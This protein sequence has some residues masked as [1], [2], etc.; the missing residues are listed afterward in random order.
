M[1]GL[2]EELHLALETNIDLE[3][4]AKKLSDPS[5]RPLLEISVEN[6]CDWP[7]NSIAGRTNPTFI[8]GSKGITEA[9]MLPSSHFPHPSSFHHHSPSS[10]EFI[11]SSENF[12]KY[13]FTKIVDLE[14]MTQIDKDREDLDIRLN[15]AQT[16]MENLNYCYRELTE[17]LLLGQAQAGNT[18]GPSADLVPRN[19]RSLLNLATVS[20]LELI[21]YHHLILFLV[22]SLGYELPHR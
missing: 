3:S 11:T 2:R 14:H 15:Q 22:I 6:E 5:R 9:S 20:A 13:L 21:P 16:E 4:H 12:T 8:T 18:L 19:S 7:V 17:C 1:N 10:E